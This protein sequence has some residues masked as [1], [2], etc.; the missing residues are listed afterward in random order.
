MT[1][2]FTKMNLPELKAEAKARKIKGFSTMKKADL[3]AALVDSEPKPV[4]AESMVDAIK[5]AIRN[6]KDARSNKGRT[7]GSE[8]VKTGK[9]GP[10]AKAQAFRLQRGSITAKMTAK[11]A[12]RVRKTESKFRVAA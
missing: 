11:Q 12:R 6:A 7:A 9:V 10:V 1:V 5:A 8:A 2:D 4:K 3:V